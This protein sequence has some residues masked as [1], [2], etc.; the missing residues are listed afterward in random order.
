MYHKFDKNVFDPTKL[1]KEL[2]ETS[3]KITQLLNNI[4][5]LDEL[6]MKNHGKNFKHFI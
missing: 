2:V 4:K 5:K 1:N 3:P 6:D